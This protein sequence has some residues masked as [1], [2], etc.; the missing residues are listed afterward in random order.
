MSD[1]LVT[2]GLI[3]LSN[4]CVIALNAIA[5]TLIY[6]A[7]RTLNLAHGDVFAL[8]SV[9]TMTILRAALAQPE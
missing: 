5:L 3:G 9:L 1:I 4:G 8:S 7:V 2:L 6:S